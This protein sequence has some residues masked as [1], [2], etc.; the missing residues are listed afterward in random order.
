MILRIACLSVPL[1]PLAARLRAEPPLAGQA[2]VVVEGSGGAARVVAASRPARRAGI[3]PGASLAQ[4]RAILPKLLARGRDLECERAAEEALAEMAES[5]SPRVE[6][7]GGGLVFLDATGLERIFRG[8]NPERELVRSLDLA[9]EKLRLPARVGLAGSKLAAR[10]AAESSRGEPVVVPAGE[11]ASFL[12]P[13]PLARL[14]PE[15]DIA[16][17]LA[18]WGIHSVGELAR[19]P[20][21]EIGSRLGRLG[22]ELQWT[23]RGHDPRPLVPRTP[24]PTFEEGMELDW[25]LVALEPF[26]VLGRATLERLS[27]RLASHGLAARRLE[28]VLGLEPDGEELRTIELP[29]PTRDPAALTALVRLGLESR[30]PAGPILRFRF[31]AYPDRP[32]RAQLSLFGPPAL[33]PDR[34]ASVVARIASLL[35]TD[36]VGSP[37]PDD[38]WFPGSFVDSPYD[39]PPPPEM[40]RLPKQGR[41]L[42]AVRTL[43]PPVEL[44]VLVES[45]SIPTEPLRLAQ[46]AD[47]DGSPPRLRLSDAPAEPELPTIDSD[48]LPPRTLRPLH[49]GGG[50]AGFRANG[51]VRVASGPWTVEEG[52]WSETPVDRAYW[53][54]ELEG[55]LLLRIYRE[56]STGRWF[57]DGVYD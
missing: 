51:P 42:L 13:L 40:R 50:E 54:V 7:V 4:A 8:G 44:E 29:A 26:L 12:A 38:S 34:L 28:L 47:G 5:F 46:T 11:E 36:R 10:V 3:R 32:R 21:A 45:T 56:R 22:Q 14:V 9:A 55:G 33:S 23:A 27:D 6:S 43:R 24:P 20:E 2:V 37:S 16:E 53:D 48:R 19:L 57:A 17:T 18:R 41:G 15:V 25:P 39:P 1:F 35:G 31:S 30:P 49:E 52:W